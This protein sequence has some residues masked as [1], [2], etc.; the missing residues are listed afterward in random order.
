MIESIKGG[1]II[2]CQA[3]ENEPMHSSFIMGRFARAAKMAGA[4]GIRANTTEDIA[5]IKKEVDLPVIGIIKKDYED[6]S[7]YITPTMEEIDRLAAAKVDIIA[8][9]ATSA[10]RPGGLTLDELVKRIREKYGSSIELMAD[11]ATFEE[12]LHAQELGFDYI[13]TTLRGY[14][15]DTRG[16]K[17][18]DFAHIKR[19]VT[20]L[21]TPVIAEG[22]IHT[23]E[24]LKRVMDLGVYCAV[25]GGAITRPLEIGKR[26]VDAISCENRTEASVG[27][28][29]SW[30]ESQMCSFNRAS[31]GI[32]ERI[33]IDINELVTFSRPDCNCETARAILLHRI[34]NGCRDY[35]DIYENIINWVLSVQD[36]DEISAWYG[37]FPFFLVNGTEKSELGNVRYQNDN[38]KVLTALLDMYELTSD[39]RLLEAAVK[40]A[41]FW[42]SVQRE[43]GYFRRNDGVCWTVYD[44]PCFI[45]WL[46]AGLYQCYHHTRNE[47]YLKCAD[48]AFDHMT[49][50]QLENGRF[51]TSYEMQKAEEWRP[52]SSETAIAVYCL[53]KAYKYTENEKIRSSAQRAVGFLISLQHESGGILNC[54]KDCMGAS[55]QEREDL[56]DLVYTQGYALMALA[57]YAQVFEDEAVLKAAKRLG[58]FLMDIQCRGESPLWD[59]AW[60]GAYSIKEKAWSGRAD[61]NN[62][63]DEGGMYSVYT[64]WCCAPIITGLL[65]LEEKFE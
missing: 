20:E 50:L 47:K 64:G 53:S 28:C 12:A 29:L 40:L 37:S 39:K 15:E 60:R 25:V 54:S 19:L 61:Q 35:D 59:G 63:I 34:K 36:N 57:E 5:E 31:H 2:S 58:G 32:Y 13:G 41:D 27:A 48:K 16:I 55:L 9:D 56:C 52:A 26:F 17:L 44:T 8:L 51:K 23:P 62:P 24:E 11:T 43:A 6:S 30:I 49:E 3:L 22:G 33:R 10:L 45:A 21:K 42:C 38:G 18:P 65:M 46:M 4:V 7:V 14:T 1:L